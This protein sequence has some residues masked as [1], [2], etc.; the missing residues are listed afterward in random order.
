MVPTPDDVD[1]SITGLSGWIG[2]A[3]AATVAAALGLRRWLSGDSAARA[4]NKTEVEFLQTLMEQLKEANKRAEHAERERNEAVLKIG[5]LKA[6]IATLQAAV[7]H[8]Q[9]Q[10]NQLTM[11]NQ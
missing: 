7:E 10:I 5:E 8:M 2:A 1:L 11:R 9:V 4:G 3:I 6:Q